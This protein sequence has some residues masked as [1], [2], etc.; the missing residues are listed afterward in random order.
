MGNVE[1]R[2]VRAFAVEGA[3][4]LPQPL[5]VLTVIDESGSMAPKRKDVIGG[6][7]TF[8]ADQQAQPGACR[9]ILVK[10]NTEKSVAFKATPLENVQPLTEAT[11]TPGGGT[12]LFDAVAE[13]VRL[14]DADKDPDERVLC[15]ILTDGE[16]NSSKETTRDQL[17]AIIK[18]REGR[19]DWTFTY[20]GA[21]PEKFAKEGYVTVASAAQYTPNA[22]AVAFAAMSR[23]TTEFRM[24]SARRTEA[25][26]TQPSDDTTEKP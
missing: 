11:Y 15:L 14:A 18:E 20:M 17:L 2:P 7:N 23:S 1:I 19:G 25:F 24:S 22:P 5:L 12:A 4:G 26:Y 3:E 10:F 16:E 9:M 8:L 6:F 13:A 21:D